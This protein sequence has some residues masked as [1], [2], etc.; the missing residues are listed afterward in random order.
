MGITH[1][2]R[3]EEHVNGTPKYLLLRR[4]A[5]LDE[6]AAF[7]HLPLLVN[8]Q[9][10]KLS[11]RRD[12]VLVGD[13]RG[14]GFLPEAMRNYLALLGWGPDD[15]V[16]VRPIE[17]IVERFR[18]EDVTPSPAFFD[19]KK[20]RLDQ[21]RVHPGARRRR[22]SSTRRAVPRARASRRGRRSRSLADRGARPGADAR[23]GRA[24]DRLPLSRRAEIDEAAWDKAMVNGRNAGA[25]LDAIDRRPRRRW[26][27]SAGRRTP[28]R[29]AIEAAAGRRPAWSTPRASLSCPR[30]RPGAGRGHRAHGRAAAV[31]VAR[32]AGSR[33]APWRGSRRRGSGSVTTLHADRRAG[34]RRSGA[35]A[36]DRRVGLA[37]RV[38]LW[39]KAD[40]RP[41]GRCCSSTRRSRS[42]RCGRR[43]ARTMPVPPTRSSCS[44]PRSTTAGRRPCSR[45]RLDHAL[46]ALPSPASRRSSSSPAAGERATASPRRR[47]ATTSSGA[48]RC[49]TAPILKEVHGRSTWESLSAVARFLR[50]RKADR[51]RARLRSG[52]TPSASARWPAEV[53][54]RTPRCRPARGLGQPRL[55]APRDRRGRGRPDHRLP[56]ARPPRPP[57]SLTPRSSRVL[58]HVGPIAIVGSAR[59]FGGGVIGNTAGSGPVVGGS[60][61]PPRATPPSFSTQ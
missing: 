2:I 22:S 51:R 16:E 14:R 18:L 9:R 33:R 3:G 35:G 53:G 37:R 1:V 52:S 26:T 28:I 58:R 57:R 29:E 61:P 38:P 15:G 20:L 55:A 32:R 30:P 40:R 6:P 8:E 31:R 59:P 23:R 27:T 48:G 12:D 11:K 43:R 54:P 36:P 4:G 50:Q 21:R 39:L 34:G 44:A 45:S 17:E 42:C 60:S 56:P 47:P 49:P 25:M 7:A 10:K 5:R 41:A 13:Y 24:D 19:I 46:V